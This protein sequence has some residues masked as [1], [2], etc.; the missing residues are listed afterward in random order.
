MFAVWFS[1]YETINHPDRISLLANCELN[2]QSLISAKRDYH[3]TA[4]TFQLFVVFFYRVC[5]LTFDNS[6]KN[7]S[8]QYNQVKKLLFI[9][10]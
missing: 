5:I 1:V 8:G 9:L 7:M 2:H 6:P 4:F 10:R 3:G